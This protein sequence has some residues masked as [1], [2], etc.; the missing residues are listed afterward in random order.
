MFDFP[1]AIDSAGYLAL[2]AATPAP[3][4][5]VL[6][7]WWGLTPFFHSVCDRLAQAGYVAL[8]PDLYHGRTADT[9]EAAEQL[10]KQR[11]LP[12]MQATAS[13]A[14]DY[15]RAH[16]AVAGP[17]ATLGFSMGASWAID[18]ASEYPQAIGAA[19]LFYGSSA[20]DFGAAR[21]AYLGHYAAGDPWEPDEDIAQMQAAMRAAGRIVTF[22]TYPNTQHWFM[23]TNRPE[24][25]AEAAALAWQ[26]TL[27]FLDEQ[28]NKSIQ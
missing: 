1:D 18:L 15:L 24:Y 5:L 13:A 12:R 9:I 11:D 21:A 23:E 8:A 16:A 20:A 19:V 22:H 17:L 7:A 14:L 25:N 2:P 6:H 28:L 10:L 27:A 26:R 4:V 3:G